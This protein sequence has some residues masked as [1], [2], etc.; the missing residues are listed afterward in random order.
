MGMDS[1]VLQ[2]QPD[3]PVIRVGATVRHLPQPWSPA[4]RAL[5]THLESVDFPCA[6]RQLGFDDAGREMLTYLPGDSGVDGWSRV[7][8]E[9]GLRAMA[10]LL[11]D[12]HRAVAG[13][14]L[15]DGL[16]FAAPGAMPGEDQ[17]VCHG[18]VGPW[19]VVWDGVRPTGLID[20]EYAVEAPRR[21]DIGYALTW[22]VPFRSDEVT[23][24][25]HHFPVVPD[26]AR[27]LEI[28][29][30]G[31][32]L[33]SLDG[34]VDAAIDAQRA[35]IARVRL[36]AAEGRPR[37]RQWVDGGG[38]DEDEAWVTWAEEHRDLVT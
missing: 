35:T 10:R 4:V 23:L 32:G 33:T 2:D 18:D 22:V 1:E 28:F 3:R 38:V 9:R 20:W 12:Y 17:V 6:P 8:D 37:Q 11:R 31:Y 26:R 36:L 19:N 30:A 27:R 14:C 29:A 24:R 15:P 16:A 21:Y 25:W 13:F 34:L 7:V 5:L